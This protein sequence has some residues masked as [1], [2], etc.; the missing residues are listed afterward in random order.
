LIEA[1]IEL[2]CQLTPADIVSAVGTREIAREADVS[3]ATF[4]HHFGSV[5]QFTV[6][7]MSEI[8]SPNRLLRGDKVRRDL[9]SVAVDALP[10]SALLAT[11]RNALTTNL[12][13]PEYR[14]KHGLWSLG[15]SSVDSHYLDY[16][17]A[18]DVSIAIGA[19]Q[20]LESWGREPRPPYDLA[21]L[22]AVGN[23]LAHGAYVRHTLDP[24]LFSIER[25]ALSVT[26][27][28]LVGVRLKGDDRSMA[29]RLAEMNY[30]PRDS[31]PSETLASSSDGGNKERL[32]GAAAE[33]FA[34]Y[35]VES[36]SVA[37]LAKRANVSTSTFFNLFGSKDR[38]A[39]ALFDRH[40][41]LHAAAWRRHLSPG[42]AVKDHL[43]GV[44]DLVACY[45]ELARIFLA[46]L[47][48]D[49]SGMVGASLVDPLVELLASPL[50]TEMTRSDHDVR[51]MA[52]IMVMVAM[53]RTLRRPALGVES[54]AS[55]AMRM[56]SLGAST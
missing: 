6:E 20:M 22:I 38:L 29:D 15:G 21:G 28:V 14:L 24:E 11:Y 16:L 46:E 1:G 5:D 37:R 49:D 13:D 18:V 27:T 7:L 52:Q 10:A 8:Y 35:G 41:E 3:S 23:A 34:E 47:A 36:T 39:V 56:L 25:F 12:G 43:T 48:A 2:L 44:A 9:E 33:L 32:L 53:Q 50:R 40:A 51:D 42:D 26:S 4:F 45:P 31:A 17:D 55:W 30:Y 19:S 54:A